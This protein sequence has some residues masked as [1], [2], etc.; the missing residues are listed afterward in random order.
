MFNV[1]FIAAL[2]FSSVLLYQLPRKASGIFTVQSKLCL[3]ASCHLGIFSAGGMDLK[4][5][6]N[7]CRALLVSHFKQ[8]LYI[9]HSHLADSSCKK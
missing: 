8:H 6:K 3:S 9:T 4:S 2:L 1:S 7:L 5:A